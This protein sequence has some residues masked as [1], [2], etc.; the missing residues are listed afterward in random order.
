MAKKVFVE[1]MNQT[2]MAYF[3]W[4]DKSTALWGLKEGYKNSADSLV[5]IA[6]QKG[7]E[8][9]IGTL[10]TYV[11]P[12][13]FL[14]RHSLEI[15]LKLIYYRFFGKVLKGH[16]L[17]SLWNKVYNEIIKDINGEDFL[18]KV[19]QYKTNFVKWSTEDIEFNELRD[20]FDELQVVDKKSDVWRY[21]I[22]NN[23]TLVFTDGEHIDYVNL[24]N[25]FDEVFKKLDYLYQIVSE[26]LSD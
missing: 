18:T 22:D 2:R 21:L 9:D 1:T 17:D 4:Q 23:Q 16:K 7:A 6:L 19:K 10:D 14:Y 13:L 11:F 3:G 8:G 25:V 20:I 12:I 15:S 5:D 26:Y 24:R